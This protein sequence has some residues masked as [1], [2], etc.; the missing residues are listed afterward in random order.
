MRQAAAQTTAATATNAMM[1]GGGNRLGERRP[2]APLRGA[3]ETDAGRSTSVESAGTGVGLAAT[4]TS[5]GR[6]GSET[7]ATTESAWIG[8][9]GMQAN[10][11]IDV[12]HPSTCTFPRL[13]IVTMLQAP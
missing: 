8:S 1:E 10:S 7:A 6:G 2:A 12:T 13:C 9:S 4:G 11:S 5:A 3:G